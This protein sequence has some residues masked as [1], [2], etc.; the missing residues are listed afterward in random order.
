MKP[1]TTQYARILIGGA[2]LMIVSTAFA[3][4]TVVKPEIIVC[5][6]FH[7]IE[8]AEGEIT[9][10]VINIDDEVTDVEITDEEAGSDEGEEVVINEEIIDDAEITDEH[11]I[12]IC[13]DPD[14]VKR[15]N[16]SDDSVNPEY[17]YMTAGGPVL[18]SQGSAA[19]TGPD[20]ADE[21][22]A[23]TMVEAKSVTA[24]ISRAASKPTA[25]KA[26]GR[27]FLR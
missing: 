5:E 25:V 26:N 7:G 3:E 20:A 8:P 16:D 27:V 6:G 15:T 9:D 21:K 12:V 4:E 2:A 14:W 13:W 10:E 19:S 17:L 23:V 22:S 24:K 18:G 1:I 11:D